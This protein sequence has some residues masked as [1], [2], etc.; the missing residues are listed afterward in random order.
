MRAE[1]YRRGKEVDWGSIYIESCMVT[2]MLPTALCYHE[3]FPMCLG[4]HGLPCCDS[5]DKQNCYIHHMSCQILRTSCS[6]AWA[7]ASDKIFPDANRSTQESH[8]PSPCTS[9]APSNENQCT[10]Y[11]FT[12][13]TPPNR[14]KASSIICRPCTPYRVTLIFFNECKVDVFL[15]FHLQ[16]FV[17]N[18]QFLSWCVLGGEDC[19]LQHWFC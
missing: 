5:C 19:L 1:R 15:R 6:I 10:M 12:H 16:P 11:T 4:Y 2:F 14:T 18:L 8:T 9:H 7:F 17:I 3:L 13:H